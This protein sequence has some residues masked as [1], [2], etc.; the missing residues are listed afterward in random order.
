MRVLIIGATGP[1]GQ[2]ITRKALQEEHAV[3]A[4]VRDAARL[5]LRN[6]QLTVALGDVLQMGAIDAPMVAQ[7]AVIC[8]LGTKPA[9]R[10]IDLFSRGTE[11]ILRAMQRH[12]VRRII[13]ISGVGAGNSKGHGGFFYNRVL[14]PLLLRSIYED[15]TRQEQ[16]VRKSD[17]D[18]CIVRPARLTAEKEREHYGAVTRMEGLQATRI[19]RADTAAFVVKQITSNQYLYRAP[20]L[21][22]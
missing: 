14:Q 3:T 22:Y 10:P 11:I 13:C 12:N 6:P 2:E 16:L 5:P 7:H 1:L 15:K 19:S 17:R 4:L 8:C 9:W 20:V 18:W 21:T